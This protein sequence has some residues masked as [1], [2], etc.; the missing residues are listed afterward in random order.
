M[1]ITINENQANQRCDRFLRK[2]CKPYPQVR[3]SDIYSRIRKGEVRLNGKRVKEETRLSLWDILEFSEELLGKKDKN[4]MLS[5]N[6]RKLILKSFILGFCMRMKIGSY[7]INQ[8]GLCFIQVISTGMIFVWM[9]ILNDT[10]KSNDIP[11]KI[12][13]L[14]LL[15]DIDLIKIRPESWSLLRI[16]KHYNISIAS[17]EKGQ[18][19]KTI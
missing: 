10:V 8:L 17:L 9:T 1:Q 19:V 7:S 12:R 14:S 18:L 2:Y 11:T 5:Q 15:L 3:L 16:M 4:L 13:F 6:S